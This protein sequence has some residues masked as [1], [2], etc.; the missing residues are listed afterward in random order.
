M[1]AAVLPM[2]MPPLPIVRVFG[3]VS[4][5][6][7][8]AVSLLVRLRI[9]I[10]APRLIEPWLAG[11][12]LVVEKNTFVVEPGTRQGVDVAGGIGPPVGRRR[13]CSS[14]RRR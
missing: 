12:G 7:W 4:V 6:V 1:L 14:T 11:V 9:D 10:G 13:S 8:A 3:L 2:V 5:S